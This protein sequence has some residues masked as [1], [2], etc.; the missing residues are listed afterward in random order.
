MQEKCFWFI[1][2]VFIRLHLTNI[3]IS[4]KDFSS[5]MTWEAWTNWAT[6]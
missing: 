4:V 2:A 5:L 1:H 3:D 6:R